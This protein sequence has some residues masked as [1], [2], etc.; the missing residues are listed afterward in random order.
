MLYL[1]KYFQQAVVVLKTVLEIEPNHTK[2]IILNAQCLEY[3]F[4][5]GASLKYLNLKTRQIK[6]SPELSVHEELIMRRNNVSNKLVQNWIQEALMLFPDNLQIVEKA[7]EIDYE[8]Q[9]VN[10][11]K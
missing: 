4:G 9:T 5:F 10:Q 3:S 8:K 2:S 11:K 6:Q 1:N 7:T